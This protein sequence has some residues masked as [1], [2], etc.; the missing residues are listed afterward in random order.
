MSV[1]RAEP[2]R[3][4]TGFVADTIPFSSVDGPGN[5]FVVFLQGC[6]F[7]CVACH[8]PQTIPGHAPV[9]GHHPRH[10]SVGDLVDEIRRAAPFIR[11]ITV[12]GGEATQ[13][14]DFV[15]E[16]FCAV[17]ADDQLTRLTLLVD[18]N[19]ACDPD[20]WDRLGPVMDGAM[21]DLKSFDPDIHLEMTG[22]P[23]DRVLASIRY[24]H[25]MDRLH[26]VRLLLVGGVNDDPD[27]LRRTGAWLAEVDPTMRVVLIGFRPHGV[28]AHDPPLVAPT[29]VQLDEAAAILRSVAEFDMTIV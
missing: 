13:Q 2:I 8:N 21:I 4:V 22:Q 18:S 3:D 7:D 19:G 20:T 12:S 14:P 11:G 24:V 15:V 23:N 16:L 29:R 28:R 9:E 1:L 10:R 25:A 27:L 5:R 6:N 26:E 17:R